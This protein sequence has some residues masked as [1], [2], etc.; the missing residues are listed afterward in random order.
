MR[1]GLLTGLFAAVLMTGTGHAADKDPNEASIEYRQAVL[2]V[3]YANFVP[4]A[5]MAKDRIDFDAEAV[6]LRANR[7][8][9]MSTMIEEAF[10]RDTRGSGYETR[11]LEPIWENYEDFTEKA[12]NL[13]RAAAALGA[14]ASEGEDAFKKAFART[15]GA[16]K[17]CH[18]EYRSD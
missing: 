15:G 1:K 4:L 8:R 17:G 18:D 6:E 9:M 13:T 5:A 14:S 2:T 16:C 7:V 10:R 11:A 12:R 3:T